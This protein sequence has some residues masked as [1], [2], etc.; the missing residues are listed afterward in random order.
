[1]V[2]EGAA[3]ASKRRQW[4]KM[5]EARMRR[6]REGAWRAETTRREVIRRGQFWLR[7]S[8]GFLLI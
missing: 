8:L 1:M 7:W 3:M 4:G 2:R 5:E 6:E